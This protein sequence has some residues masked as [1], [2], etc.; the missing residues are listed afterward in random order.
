MNAASGMANGSADGTMG[1]GERDSGPAG[2]SERTRAQ[3]MTFDL[4]KTINDPRD[5]RIGK[6]LKNLPAL[7][8][9]GFQA[10]RRLLDVQ[11]L[12]HDAMIGEDAFR[13]VNEPVVVDRSGRRWETPAASA[14]RP[15]SA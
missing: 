12:S 3:P 2:S 15:G 7:R 13:Q 14:N 8:R 1:A 11:R 10:N 5:F 4:L 6:R 9:I